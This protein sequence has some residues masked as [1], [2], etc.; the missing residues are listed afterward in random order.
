MDARAFSSGVALALAAL[1]QI[2]SGKVLN[3]GPV[4]NRVFTK[5]SNDMEKVIK[6]EEMIP[7]VARGSRTF[8]K[9]SMGVAP[10]FI[11]A[12]SRLWGVISNWG[13]M[14]R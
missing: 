8:R 12:S 13:L 4:V 3:P 10:R 2:T 1:I 14:A 7:G 11:A 6:T 9:A 5:S